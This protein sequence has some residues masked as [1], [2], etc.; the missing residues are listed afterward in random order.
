MEHIAALILL[1]G[2]DDNAFQCEEIP[3]PTVGYETVELCEQAVA[4]TLRMQGRN[5]PLVIAKC[6]PVDPAA[7]GDMEIVWD[8]DR[9]GQLHA[10]IRPLGSDAA[11]VSVASETLAPTGKGS[12]LR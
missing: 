12:R 10:E 11:G 2:C 8:V 9:L 5:Y 4:P 1:L 6:I 7:E 3:A